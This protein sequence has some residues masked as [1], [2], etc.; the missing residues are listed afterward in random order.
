MP[1]GLTP[2]CCDCALPRL[3]LQPDSQAPRAQD[4]LEEV[5]LRLLE[6][7]LR[8]RHQT[9]FLHRLQPV[10]SPPVGHEVGDERRHAVQT[11]PSSLGRRW[12]VGK[13][14][15]KAGDN[16]FLVEELECERIAGDELFKNFGITK[17]FVLIQ[18]FVWSF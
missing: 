9:R 13:R 11:P 14:V 17:R 4:T 8:R 10:H 3:R 18:F 2:V 1:F 7:Q 5:A 12:D 15:K 6:E 16:A